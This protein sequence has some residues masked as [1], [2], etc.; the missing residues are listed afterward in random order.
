MPFRHMPLRLVVLVSI[1]ALAACGEDSPAPTP[2]GSLVLSLDGAPVD[3]IQAAELTSRKALEAALPE[4][5]RDPASW[6]LVEAFGLS[7]HLRLPEPAKTYRDQDLV[8]YLDA[9]GRPSL[10]VFRRDRPELSAEV[11]RLIREPTVALVA[12]AEVRVWTAPPPTQKPDAWDL[13]VTVDGA[14]TR[15]AAAALLALPEV[16]SGE[17]AEG[18]TGGGRGQGR[19]GKR[20]RQG[21]LLADVI[22]LGTKGKTPT[23][24]VLHGGGDA[25]VEVGLEALGARTGRIAVFKRNKRG[26]TLYRIVDA[27][28]GDVVETPL[29]GVTRIEV[30]TE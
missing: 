8:L 23:M 9:E 14:E 7:R 1:L 24:V 10:G 25:R 26:E 2:Q 30:K 15:L 17:P 22:A 20:G 5:A 4:S 12:A 29:R 11:R 28:T 3:T 18:G 13:A 6:K 19:K 16:E 27:A 21:W